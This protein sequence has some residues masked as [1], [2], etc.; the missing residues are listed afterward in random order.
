MFLE[1]IKVSQRSFSDG[2]ISFF[3][4]F[5]S[6]SRWLQSFSGGFVCLLSRCLNAAF[7]FDATI[8]TRRIRMEVLGLLFV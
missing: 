5:V 6:F 4:G 7:E 8:V 3:G 2:F 1:Q